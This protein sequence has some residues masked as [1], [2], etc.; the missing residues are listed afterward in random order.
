MALNS[1]LYLSLNALY[2]LD[3]QFLLIDFSCECLDA[4]KNTDSILKYH[5]NGVFV[6]PL[7]T[8]VL[9]IE[10][11]DRPFFVVL[12]CA[13]LYFILLLYDHSVMSLVLLE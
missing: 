7:A 9:W 11:W 3:I 1:L 6:C 12:C 4:L 13:S 10:F 8:S 5:V 2:E